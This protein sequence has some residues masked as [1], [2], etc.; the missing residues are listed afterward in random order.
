MKRLLVALAFFLAVV[1]TAGSQQ[2]VMTVGDQSIAGTKTFTGVLSIGGSIYIPVCST[3]PQSGS[4]TTGDICLS[5][6]RSSW[7][8][9]PGGTWVEAAGGGGGSGDVQG[10]LSST[11][12]AIPT[13]TGVDGDE[14]DEDL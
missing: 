6:V 2:T 5:F 3:D 9:C 13:F 14:I 4:C 10:P 11:E 1:G 8:I 7:F 12:D